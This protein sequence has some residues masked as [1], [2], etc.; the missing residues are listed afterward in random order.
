MP[1]GVRSKGSPMCFQLVY[2]LDRLLAH[3]INRILIGEIIA[4][5][6]RIEGVP[7]GPVFFQIAQGRADPSLGSARMAAGGI[8]FCQDG[9]IAALAGVE[10]GHQAG[11][12][13]AD[14]DS[15]KLMRVDHLLHPYQSSEAAGAQ[16]NRHATGQ[17]QEEADTVDKAGEHQIEK[18]V[19]HVIVD[20]KAGRRSCRGPCR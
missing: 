10:S 5:F 12:A 4:A 3:D 11:A 18:F 7:F 6:D 16:N 17:N 13:R 20:G 1:S 8:E 14:N 9:R 19:M 2:D 15:F